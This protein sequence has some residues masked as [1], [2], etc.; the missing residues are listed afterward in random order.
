MSAHQV[1]RCGKVER[2]SRRDRFLLPYATVFYFYRMGDNSSYQVLVLGG[3]QET[4]VARLV[5]HQVDLVRAEVSSLLRGADL[6]GEEE[7]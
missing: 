3:I 7:C 1:H 4:H 6:G 2:S 5:L